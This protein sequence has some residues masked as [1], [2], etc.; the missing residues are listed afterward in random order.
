[1]H[2]EVFAVCC[3]VVHPRVGGNAQ[4]FAEDEVE[5]CVPVDDQHDDG[6]YGDDA[7]DVRVVGE[8]LGLL[9]KFE[10]AAHFDE[11]I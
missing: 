7:K 10:N 5:T 3:R 2:E 6:E 8:C 11:P 9:T 1:M 4:E